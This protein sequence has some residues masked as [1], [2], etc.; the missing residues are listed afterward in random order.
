MTYV[1]LG[2]IV[3]CIGLFVGTVFLHSESFMGIHNEPPPFVIEPLDHSV[4]ALNGIVE[5][6]LDAARARLKQQEEL[7]ATL[8]L[9]LETQKKMDSVRENQLRKGGASEKASEPGEKGDAGVGMGWGIRRTFYAERVEERER[10]REREKERDREDV[11]GGEGG[12]W[13]VFVCVLL[14]VR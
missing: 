2:G 6:E 10:K 11:G 12:E 1:A 3:F 4:T 14:C 7:L 9:E 8:K 13:C 5:S